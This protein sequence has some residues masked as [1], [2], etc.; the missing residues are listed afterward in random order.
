M[1]PLRTLDSRQNLFPKETFLEGHSCLEGPFWGP[2]WEGSR[3]AIVE[4]R[5]QFTTET[6]CGV[7]NQHL[8]VANNKLAPAKSSS[9]DVSC[10]PGC[11][12]QYSPWS[13]LLEDGTM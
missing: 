7:V 8:E 1:D 2:S 12:R 10:T 3:R 13:E 9:R 5:A 6:W 4:K 11:A